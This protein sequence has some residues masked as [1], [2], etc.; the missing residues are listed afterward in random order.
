MKNV[1]SD[2]AE[3]I[4][5][6]LVKEEGRNDREGLSIWL[7]I[8]GHSVHIYDNQLISIKNGIPQKGNIIHK[9]SCDCTRQSLLGP[10]Y[11]TYCQHIVAGISFLTLRHYLDKPKIKRD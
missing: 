5:N 6:G 11:S 2:A 7:I 8:D 1:Y 4:K 10:K 9:Y 3:L